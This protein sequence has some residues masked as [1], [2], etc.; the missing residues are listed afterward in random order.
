MVNRNKPSINLWLKQIIDNCINKH[1]SDELQKDYLQETKSTDRLWDEYITARALREAVEEQPVLQTS[2]WDFSISE[3]SKECLNKL[4]IDTMADLLQFS[5]EELMFF[6]D[7]IEIDIKEIKNFLISQKYRLPLN[8][9]N[10]NKISSL[11]VIRRYTG[12]YESEVKRAFESPT[13]LKA[14]NLDRPSLNE[15]W[16]KQFYDLF[17]HTEKEEQLHKELKNVRLRGEQTDVFHSCYREFFNVVREISYTYTEFCLKNHIER[18]VDFPQIPQNIDEQ[19]A[20]PNYM[21]TTMKYQALRA[22]ISV[23]KRLGCFCGSSMAEFFKASD[24]EKLNIAEKEA[25]DNL[26]LLM[27]LYVELGIDFEN[28]IFEFIDQ[29]GVHT[30]GNALESLINPWL[31][32]LIEKY[33]KTH[34]AEEMRTIYKEEADKN[35]NLSWDRFLGEQALLDAIHDNPFLLAKIEELSWDGYIKVTLLEKGMLFVCDMMQ[36]T[37]SDYYEMFD[38]NYSSIH[39]INRLLKKYHLEIFSG[40]T[41]TLKIFLPKSIGDENDQS[42]FLSEEDNPD[43]L[44][45]GFPDDLLPY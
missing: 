35:H 44:E 2:V 7:Y 6:S 28:L 23:Y 33:R 36:Y 21:Y 17:G 39:S 37:T 31:R 40:D 8:G 10:P 24:E 43:S 30:D 22:L 3:E 34:T 11:K 29:K 14:F 15:Q 27:I 18:E 12:S 26:Q 16:F 38:E 4:Y 19:D 42:P 20:V 41:G 9:F 25:E 13:L 45:D 1:S 32:T 5:K